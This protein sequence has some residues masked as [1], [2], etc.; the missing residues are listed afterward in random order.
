[1]SEVTYEDAIKFFKG[2][3]DLWGAFCDGI[4]E[5]RDAYIAD[6]KRNMGTPACSPENYFAA[7][8]AMVA[9]DDLLYDFRQPLEKGDSVE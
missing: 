4:Q 5:R 1:M 8:G 6:V 9:V 7:N 3:S 2:Q